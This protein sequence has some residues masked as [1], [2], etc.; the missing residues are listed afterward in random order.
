MVLKFMRSLQLELLWPG[1][2]FIT[3]SY[4]FCCVSGHYKPPRKFSQVVYVKPG[5]QMKS[6]G[7][8]PH[9]RENPLVLA[10][11]PLGFIRFDVRRELARSCYACSLA[12]T[13]TKE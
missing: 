7:C 2:L 6:L 4:F 5:H 13:R 1:F 8:L 9:R 11:D 3:P 12:R 10:H